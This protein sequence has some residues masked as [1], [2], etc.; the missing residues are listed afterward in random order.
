MKQE[1]NGIHVHVIVFLHMPFSVFFHLSFHFL[2]WGHVSAAIKET[3]FCLQPQTCHLDPTTPD[4]FFPNHQII[5]ILSTD[6]HN[7]PQCCFTKIDGASKE[8][9]WSS[10]QRR[11]PSSQV[12]FVLLDAC[13][14]PLGKMQNKSKFRAF[15]WNQNIHANRCINI[16]FVQYTSVYIYT[17]RFISLSLFIYIQLLLQHPM[18]KNA[19]KKHQQHTN[20]HTHITPEIVVGVQTTRNKQLRRLIVDC[21]RSVSAHLKSWDLITTIHHPGL[22]DIWVFSGSSGERITVNS[23]PMGRKESATLWGIPPVKEKSSSELLAGRGD[24]DMLIS[25]YYLINIS[26]DIVITK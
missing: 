18:P 20:T 17:Y 13:S 2:G 4:G 8:P 16:Y 19:K 15:Q 21:I 5:Q 3:C 7:C 26:K 23:W 24:V 11:L 25:N 14:F 9:L 1:S 10:W 12:L 22:V 6:G